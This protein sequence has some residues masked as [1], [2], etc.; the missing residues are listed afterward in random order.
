MNQAV[1]QQF[2]IAI[3]REIIVRYEKT[4]DA[5]CV[6]LADDLFEI[7]GRAKPA[8]P[9]LHVDDGA[10]RALIRAATPEIDARER[11]RGPPYMLPRQEWRRLAGQ[12][13]QLVHVIVKRLELS[14]PRVPQYLVEPPFFAFTG[15]KRNSHRLGV[16]NVRWQFG[17]HCDAARHVEAPDTN[18]QT[19][20]EKWTGEVD[21]TWKLVRLHADQTDQDATALFADHTN[22]AIRP[23]PPVGLIEGVESDFDFWP[24]YLAPTHVFSKCVQAGQRIGRNGRADP[25]NGIAVVVVVRRLDHH[26]MQQVRLRAAPGSRHF[27]TAHAV[28]ATYHTRTALN[29][30]FLQFGQ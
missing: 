1:E 29:R 9:A 23:H 7:V 22:D 14:V 19:C 12:R 5:L 18:W 26:K 10:E 3:T 28:A 2:P 21:G 11:A 15:K 6:I 27:A 20:G 16:F 17:Q 4:F 8:L 13:G 25:L 24:Q 30:A